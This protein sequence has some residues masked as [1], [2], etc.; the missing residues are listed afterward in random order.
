MLERLRLTLRLRGAWE[1]VDSGYALLRAHGR[2]VYALWLAAYVPVA[3]ALFWVFWERAWI[4][5][6]LVW[7]L[8]PL[9]GRFA[10]HGLAKATFGERPTILSAVKG[11]KGILRH[12]AVACQLWRRLGVNRAFVL[13]IWQL[14]GQSGHG[15]RRRAPVLLRRVHGASALFTIFS[16]ILMLGF[17][18]ALGAAFFYLV[19]DGLLDK[20]GDLFSGEHGPGP[21]FYLFPTFAIAVL[22]PFYLAGGFGLYLNRRI[23]L[24]AWDLD[25][26]F[27]R[28]AQRLKRGLGRSVAMLLLAVALVAGTGLR[29]Q[30]PEPAKTPKAELKEVLKAPEF[31]AW[32]TE[33]TWHWKNW[34]ESKPRSQGHLPEWLFHLFGLILK[35]IIIAA[36]ALGVLWFLWRFLLSRR[37]RWAERSDR[38]TA[39]EDLF[40]LDIRPGSLPKDIA[41]VAL[42]LWRGGE[43]RACLSLLYRGALARLVHERGL[44][45]PPGAT[46]GDCLRAAIPFLDPEGGGY[47]RSLTGTWQALAY[48]HQEPTDGEALCDAWRRHFGGG[49][50]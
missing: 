41:G 25:L 46:E 13:P 28:L 16:F 49:R 22:E 32:S 36:A 5:L 26:A 37:G 39:P 30:T 18:C 29:A 24:E 35:G 44:E 31:Q 40:G 20:A 3:V 48:A 17:S 43:R 34:T 21:L 8:T 11:A 45:V 27:R 6:L 42:A 12:G 14:E 19:P 4:A 50:G 15:Y 7:W 1:A 23:Q 2:I 33:R 38:A 10:L 9:L 47:F